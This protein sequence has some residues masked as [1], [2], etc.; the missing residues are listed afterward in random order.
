MNPQKYLS[1]HFYDYPK[2]Y[3]NVQ[4]MFTMLVSNVIINAKN[5]DK[6]QNKKIIY[7]CNFCNYV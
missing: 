2:M 1:G 5:A 7:T 4:S 6:N 3:N